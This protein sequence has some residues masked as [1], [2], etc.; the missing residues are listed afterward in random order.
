MV[1]PAQR[2]RPLPIVLPANFELGAPSR[3]QAP[4]RPQPPP[5]SRP[6]L[7]RIDGYEPPRPPAQLR[8]VAITGEASAPPHQRPSGHV[9]LGVDVPLSPAGTRLE[10]GAR[11][12]SG[13]DGRQAQRLDLSITDPRATLAGEANFERG[14]FT[15]ARARLTVP[16]S[17]RTTAEARAELDA[18]GRPTSVAAEARYAAEGE[19]ARAVVARNLQDRTTR[20]EVGYGRELGQGWSLEASAARELE[21]RRTEGRITLRRQ[22]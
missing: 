9:R 10:A 1:A 13:P 7:P 19:R 18:R 12:A 16:L 15:G 22:F 4:S 21:R 11:A 6:S 2:L 3:R 20:V 14:R 8:G 17:Q 5:A